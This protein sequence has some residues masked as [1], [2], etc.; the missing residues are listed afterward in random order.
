MR[1]ATHRMLHIIYRPATA[2]T[3]TSADALVYLLVKDDGNGAA[4]RGML[5]N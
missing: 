2:A 4:V 5:I 1:C 3:T